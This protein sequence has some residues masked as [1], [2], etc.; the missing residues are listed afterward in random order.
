M[1]GL[2]PKVQEYGES[3]GIPV[4]CTF[5]T[6]NRYV[7]K[8]LIENGTEDAAAVLKDFKKDHNCKKQSFCFPLLVALHICTQ[9]A[10]AKDGGGWERERE[11]ERARARNA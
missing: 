8:W 4:D 5:T 7:E 1:V 3:Q 11:R 6:F 10:R 9:R 2:W